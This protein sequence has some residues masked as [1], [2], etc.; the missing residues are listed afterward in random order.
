MTAVLDSLAAHLP[1]RR[2]PRD[3]WLG[4][5]SAGPQR[6]VAAVSYRADGPRPSVLVAPVFDAPDAGDAVLRWHR[7]EHAQARANVLLNS[8]DYRIVPL[9]PPAVPAQELRDAL[10]WRLEG[11]IDLP[12]D[13]AAIDVLQVPGASAGTASREVFAVVARA[14]TVRDWMQ[15]CRDARAWLGALDVPELAMRNLSVLAAGAQAHAFV[16]LGLKSTRL[17]LVWQHEL[18]A[19]RQ[20][21]VA[22]YKLDAADADTRAMLIERLA[23]EIQRSTDSFSRQFHGADLREVWVSAVR[24]AERI[25]QQL[26]QLLPQ[27]V[28]AFRVEDHV[29]LTSRE[30][31]VDADR[32]LDFTFPIGAA[33]RHGVH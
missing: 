11:L 12:L 33:L 32:G 21:D 29:A 4:V 28:R 7:A 10:R 20:F 17:V 2:A 13:D 1:W 3:G 25:S 22:A 24:E 14:Q 27:R 6:I 31:V 8:V 23:L 5:Y 18:C 19:F 16:H 30:P 26:A 15:R 9:E